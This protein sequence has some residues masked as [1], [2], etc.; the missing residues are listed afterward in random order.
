MNDGTVAQ[1]AVK[2]SGPGEKTQMQR[3]ITRGSIAFLSRGQ[4]REMIYVSAIQVP[5]AQVE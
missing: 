5:Y 2:W 4:A 1:F 3:G